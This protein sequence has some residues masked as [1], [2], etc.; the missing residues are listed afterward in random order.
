METKVTETT[1]TN[2]TTG[3]HAPEPKKGNKRFIIVLAILVLV[4]GTFGITK[5]IHAQHHEETDDAQIDASISP[6]IP[7]VAGYISHVYVSDN[8][9]VKKGDTLFTLDARE[10]GIKLEQA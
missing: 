2:H 10:L 5:Y 3:H 9:K 6:V 4:G 7:R 8:Q 1:K